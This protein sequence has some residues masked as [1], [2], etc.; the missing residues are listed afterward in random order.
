MDDHPQEI[1]GIAPGTEVEVNGSPHIVDKF[2]VPQPYR[3]ETPSHG[4]G[5]LRRGNPGNSGGGRKPAEV[6]DRMRRFL[7]RVLDRID[8]VLTD[9]ESKQIERAIGKEVQM[10]ELQDLTK[11]LDALAKYSVGT[12]VEVTG[13]DDGPLRHGIMALP[14][15]EPPGGETDGDDS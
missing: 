15:L 3:L 13:P 10:L 9:E 8:Q 14:P 7:D 6:R 2:G 5:L 1:E 11:L 12:K 4:H